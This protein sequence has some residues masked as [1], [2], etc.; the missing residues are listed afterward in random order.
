LK[1][2]K[3]TRFQVSTDLN[4]LDRVLLEFNQINQ[5][6]IPKKDWL[7][8]QL[9]LVEGFTNAVRHAH[10]NLPMEIPIEIEITLF[11]QN[12]EIR[13]WDCGPPFDLTGFIEQIQD[14][15]GTKSGGGR[16]I[17]ILYKIADSLVYVRLDDDRNCL[18]LNK[19]FT[20]LSQS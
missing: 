16:G 19:K 4:A 15:D 12:I 1:V 20:F 8:C 13:I 3:Q 18:I 6:W 17:P 9:A 2:I 5:L 11:E 7:Q 10:K 14:N